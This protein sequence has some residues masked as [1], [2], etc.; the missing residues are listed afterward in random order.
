MNFIMQVLMI[1]RATLRKWIDD[2]FRPV[3]FFIDSVSEQEKRDFEKHAKRLTT[4]GISV[5]AL[6][7]L[8]Q[9]IVLWPTDILAYE[10]GSRVLLAVWILRLLVGGF[11]IFALLGIRFIRIFRQYPVF[12]GIGTLT[13][14]IGSVGWMFGRT[15]GMDSPL[16]YV[17][18]SMPIASI[19]VIVPLGQRILITLWIAFVYLSA[20]FIS[21]PDLFTLHDAGPSIIWLSAAVSGAIVVGQVFYALLWSNFH[22]QHLLDMAAEEHRKLMEQQE[23]DIRE[24]GRQLDSIEDRERLKLAQDIHDE[25]GQVLAGMRMEVDHL[26][27]IVDSGDSKKTGEAFNRLNDFFVSMNESIR[28]IIHDLRPG[29]LEKLGLVATIKNGCAKFHT[30]YSIRCRVSIGIDEDSL[31]NM[32]VSNLYRIIQEAT[33]NAAKHAEASCIEVE[34]SIADEKNPYGSDDMLVLRIKDN[35][36]GFDPDKKGGDTF[37]LAGMRERAGRIGGRLEVES[38]EGRGTTIKVLFPAKEEGLQ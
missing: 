36:K 15:V 22:R 20:F 1:F 34:L 8:I 6:V 32:Q 14:G 28:F 17:I 24:L 10:S 31:S 12:F 11:C 2:F 13:L 3:S 25:L 5:V 16:F 19:L 30:R 26:H 23:H 9:D 7:L 21:K 29:A 18:Y 33:T 37:G 35:G 4:F 38:S 27:M